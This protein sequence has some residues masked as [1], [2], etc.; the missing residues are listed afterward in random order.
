MK[1]VI[2]SCSAETVHLYLTLSTRHFVQFLLSLFRVVV[3]ERPAQIVAF[4]TQKKVSPDIK[5]MFVVEIGCPDDF[6]DER[7]AG[8]FEIPRLVRIAGKG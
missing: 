3:P 2:R 1:R 4:R 5:G 8:V 7:V 6:V